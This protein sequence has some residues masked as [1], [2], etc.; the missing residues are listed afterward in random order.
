MIRSGIE[1]VLK[2]ANRGQRRSGEPFDATSTIAPPRGLHSWVHYG[3]M[4][5]DLPEPHRTFGIMSIVGTPGVAIFAND[6]AMRTTPRDTATLVS[7]TAAMTSGTF[8]SYSI[9]EDC[10]FAEDGSRIRFGEDVLITGTYPRFEVHRKHPD[11]DVF[12]KLSAT[13]KVTHFVDLPGGAY[14]H[15]SLLCQYEG[16]VGNTAVSGLCTFEYAR[17]VG[18]HTL[19]L[20]GTPKIPATFFTYH[21]MNIDESRQLLYGEAR[22]AGQIR[23]IHSAH[24]RGLDEY[25]QDHPDAEFEV[26]AY[27]DE[28]RPTPDGRLMRLPKTFTLALND[29]SPHNFNLRGQTNGDWAYGLGAGF[30][31]SYCFEGTYAGEPVSGTAYIEYVDLEATS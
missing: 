2:H 20:P 16:T 31:G 9:R 13:D 26:T 7:A 25:G 3:V 29:D 23:A 21:V 30:V 17:G 12:L 27:E 10:E 14:S 1:T 6:Y 18:L 28:P 8:H 24:T 4:V 11:A 15:W 19:P 5:P 22:L